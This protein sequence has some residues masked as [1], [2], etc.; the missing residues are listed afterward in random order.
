MKLFILALL[1]IGLIGGYTY[2]SQRQWLPSGAPKIE[3]PAVTLQGTPQEQ[4]GIFASRAQELGGLAQGFIGTSIQKDT[5]A[6]SLSQQA[7][8]YGQYLYCKQVV[9]SYEAQQPP[10]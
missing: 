9:S 4:L 7:M 10:Q 6:P 5:S 2:A 8:N 3:L 1:A